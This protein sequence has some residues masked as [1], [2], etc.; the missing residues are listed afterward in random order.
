MSRRLRWVLALALSLIALGGI[1][2]AIATSGPSS[3]RHG[4][5][6]V[7]QLGFKVT[8]ETAGAAARSLP[9]NADPQRNPPHRYHGPPGKPHKSG[10]PAKIVQ[11]PQ[12]FFS[13]SLIWP[14]VNEWTVASR[15]TY[16]AVDAGADPTD[17]SNGVFGIFRQ[18][19]VHVRQD[20][21]LVK[22]PGT[23]ALEII[24]APLGPK[25][26]IWAQRR[27]NIHF[28]SKNGI[29]GTLHLKDDSVTLDR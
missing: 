23:G 3:G 29:S 24:K 5:V 6:F 18:D 13:T 28:T 16:T 1:G 8:Q 26:E 21:D 15:R 27:G 19:F 2:V 7:P 20:Q 25:V 11:H 14:L 12:G 17:R 22:V 10:H 4:L 9:R